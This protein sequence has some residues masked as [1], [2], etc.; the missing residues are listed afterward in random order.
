MY[1]RANNT[2][3]LY[4]SIQ[5][6]QQWHFGNDVGHLNKF[7]LHQASLVWG[8]LT[9]SR[10]LSQYVISRLGQLSLLPYSGMENE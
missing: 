7:T 4:V 9:V 2:T 10:I 8:W 3:S 5:I 1:I 6:T